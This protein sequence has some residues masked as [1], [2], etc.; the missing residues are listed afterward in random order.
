MDDSWPNALE[1]SRDLPCEAEIKSAM[2]RNELVRH[3]HGIK[4]NAARPIICVENHKPVV[5][6]F[7]NAPSGQSKAGGFFAADL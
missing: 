3:A 5:A 2:A 4:V 1:V 6:T 7:T